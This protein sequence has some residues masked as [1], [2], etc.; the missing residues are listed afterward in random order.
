M[1]SWIPHMLTLGNGLSGFAA[2]GVLATAPTETAVIWVGLFMFAA[3]TFDMLDGLAA[4]T[5]RVSGPFGAMLDSLCDA[6]S[7]GVAPA[8]VVGLISRQL[9]T[10]DW[11]GWV[12]GAVY[13]AA[14]LLRL[15]RY[16]VH[17]VEPPDLDHGPEGPRVFEGLSSPA[18]AMAVA[19]AMLVVPSL[20]PAV[21]ALVA[22]LMISRL[23]YPDV[24]ALY[25]SR[26]LPLWH[27][28]VPAAMM[29][30]LGPLP[31]MAWCLALYISTGPILARLLNEPAS[32][33]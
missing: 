6:V 18:A 16:S 27:L 21:A 12:I 19:S 25:L 31:S 29:L 23:P 15:A 13:L 7:F 4:R 17:A 28:L 3:W 20:T 22:P 5:L 32:G 9:T 14:A 2:I 10:A 24:A 11:A 1:K 33:R 26:R 30:V 8:L